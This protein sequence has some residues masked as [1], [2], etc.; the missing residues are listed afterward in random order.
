MANTPTAAQKR[1]FS[2]VVNLGCRACRNLGYEDSMAEIHH[3]QGQLGKRD[4]DRVIGLCPNHHR[5]GPF[6]IHNQSDYDWKRY[7]GES[8]EEMW[9]NTK[10]E[11]EC[12]L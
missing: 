4:H 8:E 2:Q 9:W 3:L 7:T 1:Y 6:A 10:K 12:L 11:I 5:N